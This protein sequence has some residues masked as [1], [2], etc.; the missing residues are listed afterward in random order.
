MK[1][2]IIICVSNRPDLLEKQIQLLNNFMIGEKV[3]SIVYDTRDKQ[4]ES[5]FKKICDDYNL[6]YHLH[7]SEP[8][9]APSFYHAQAATWA[10]QNVIE[11]E[12]VLMLLDHDMFLIDEFNIEDE[13]K[14]YDLM[15]CLQSRGDVKYIWPGLFLAKIK[16]IKEK[17]FHFYPDSV[18]GEFL[19][20]GGGTDMLLE[21]NLDYYDTGVEYPSDY[22]GINLD[23]SELTRGFN[24]ELHH[25]GK[26]LHFRNAC[27]WDNQFITNDSDKTNLLF[28]M[29]SD[30]MEAK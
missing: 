12:D 27:G 23:D 18:R 5:F 24:F 16:S 3:V 25:E 7:L 22:N 8:N 19:D 30:F 26:F 29:I 6:E 11:D 28:H 10:Y 15:G 2:R 20:T 14:D 17:D 13:I 9:C 21:S 1:T 4:Y